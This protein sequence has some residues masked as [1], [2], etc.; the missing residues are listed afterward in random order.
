[1]YTIPKIIHLIGKSKIIPSQFKYYTD[2]I[3]EMHP[4]WEI[5]LWDDDTALSIVGEY[6]PEWKEIYLSYPKAIQRADIFR[7][8]IIYLKGGFY[9]DM[10]MYCLKALDELCDHEIVLGIEKILTPTETLHLN[11]IYPIRI[12]NYMFGSRPRHSF[13]LDFLNEAK[14]KSTCIIKEENDVLETTGPGL[15]T[16]IF[17]KVRHKYD[18]IVLLENNEMPC[19]K[20][21]GQASC[22]F[23]YY[24]AH[25]HVGSWR[26]KP[27]ITN[28]M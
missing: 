24:A 9:M 27:C 4:K 19:P 21:C 26:W 5:I 8:M 25:Y 20:S 13:W 2:S 16:N 6:F 3:K 11:H 28:E 22:H 10:D 7:V 14:L 17:H 23:G 18:N 1:M 12:A 15:L